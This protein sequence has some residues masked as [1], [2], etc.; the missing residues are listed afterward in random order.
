MA[1]KQVIRKGVIHKMQDRRKQEVKDMKMG[2]DIFV[3]DDGWNEAAFMDVG[4]LGFFDEVA[5]LAYDIKNCARGAY[6]P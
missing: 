1:K 2:K 6:Q 4:L 3:K 5:K